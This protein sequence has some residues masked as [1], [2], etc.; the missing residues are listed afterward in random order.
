[1]GRAHE[2]PRPARR[3]R[4]VVGGRT[5]GGDQL[6]KAVATS[7]RSEG[8][9]NSCISFQARLQRAYHRRPVDVHGA[10][11][12]FSSGQDPPLFCRRIA[13]APKATPRGA[14]FQTCPS[15]GPA[16][17]HVCKHAPRQ[18]VRRFP[19]AR[20]RSTIIRPN[21][22]RSSRRVSP[23]SRSRQTSGVRGKPEFRES[24]SWQAQSHSTASHSTAPSQARHALLVPSA[25]SSV[26]N[27][28]SRVLHP[29]A[30]A[31]ALW[32]RARHV[33]FGWR[34]GR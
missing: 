18:G 1:M 32:H 3:P 9:K 24:A 23:G 28:R 8:F 13:P 21:V 31:R 30:D 2:L 4:G 26:R 25:R 14:R 6:A 29:P 16:N 22:Q 15:G 12:A 11:P 10:G 5:A 27:S 17:R 20:H 34:L 7:A 19:H 33:G